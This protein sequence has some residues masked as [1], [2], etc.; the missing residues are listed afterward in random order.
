MIKVEWLAAGVL[1]IQS[2]VG[3]VTGQIYRRRICTS[4]QPNKKQM[5]SALTKNSE[6]YKDL[7]FSINGKSEI[8]KNL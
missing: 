7:Y 3:L 8:F 1:L 2:S 6:K 5:P 4:V